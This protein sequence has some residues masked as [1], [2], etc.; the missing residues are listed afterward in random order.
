MPSHDDLG[1]YRWRST[2]Y[3]WWVVVVFAFALTLS[4]ADRLIIGLMIKPIRQDLALSNT[5]IALLQGLAFTMLYVLAGLP[6]GRLADCASRRGLAAASVIT[7]SVMTGF[8]GLSRSFGQLFAARLGVGVGEAG[9][10]PA[11]VSMVC[12]YFPAHLRARP[13][14]FL[15]I[16]ASAGAG[17]ALMFGG[18]MVQAIGPSQQ[19]VLSVIGAVRGWQAVFLVLA[20]TG[21][22]FGATFLTVREPARQDRAMQSQ[23]SIGEV[24]RFLWQ[25][26]AFF[27]PQILGPSFAVFSLIAFHSWMPTL[28][29]KQFHWDAAATGMGYGACVGLAGTAGIL[30]GGWMAQR[31]GLLGDLGTPPTVAAYAALGAFLPLVIAPLLQNPVALL[32]LLCGAMTLLVIPSALAPAMLQSVCPNGM[33]GQV[34]SVYLLFMSSFAYALG[35]LSVAWLTDHVLRSEAGMGMSL[36]LIAAIGTAGSALC[37]FTARH[38]H[39]RLLRP[40]K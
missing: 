17:L 4:L 1:T 37:L 5:D 8:C 38:Q 3:A 22:L 26:R 13:L 27:V 10:S 28:I 39:R 2:A 40:A 25:R 36:S 23:V 18:V 35:P 16:G 20:V 6:L 30:I 7:W 33:R 12:D 32:V 29:M 21:V 15:S 31:H 34:F 19:M 24:T 9:L 14:A 11:A